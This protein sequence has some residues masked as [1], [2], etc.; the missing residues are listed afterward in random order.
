MN[1]VTKYRE[2]KVEITIRVWDCL[3]VCST[4]RFSKYEHDLKRYTCLITN[5]PMLEGNKRIGL[6][7]P[8]RKELYQWD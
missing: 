7:C 4:C 3:P 1:G 5:E 6:D 8:L 2:T